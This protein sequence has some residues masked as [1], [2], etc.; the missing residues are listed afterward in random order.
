MGHFETHGFAIVRQIIPTS[1]APTSHKF[2]THFFPM[3]K[4][5]DSLK[6][7]N[8]SEKTAP[9]DDWLDSELSR[10]TATP[11][12]PYASY[13]AKSPISRLSLGLPTLP[14]NHP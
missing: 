13:A 4:P 8:P 9:R 3:T 14:T 1:M 12:P 2:P 10:L 7:P 6:Q 11:H 5:L